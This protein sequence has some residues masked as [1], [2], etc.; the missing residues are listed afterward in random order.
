[1]K[2]VKLPSLL[3]VSSTFRLRQFCTASFHR[4]A[5]HLTEC[6]LSA[7]ICLSMALIL[8][9]YGNFASQMKRV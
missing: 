9:I 8:Y 7:E 3:L 6:T 1:M 4:L 5:N 2:I